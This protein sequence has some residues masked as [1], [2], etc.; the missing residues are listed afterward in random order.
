MFKVITLTRKGSSLIGERT[1][2]IS[3]VTSTAANEQK[4]HNTY[5]QADMTTKSSSISSVNRIAKSTSLHGIPSFD[6]QHTNS[7]NPLSLR[8]GEILSELEQ[9]LKVPDELPQQLRGLLKN[10]HHTTVTI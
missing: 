10:T 7:L 2:G 4:T 1:A 5:A 9:Q 8:L 6:D 3:L